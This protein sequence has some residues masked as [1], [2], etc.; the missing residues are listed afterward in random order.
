MKDED[1]VRGSDKGGG[2]EEG[3]ARRGGRPLGRI[4]CMA[5]SGP[6]GRAEQKCLYSRELNYRGAAQCHNIISSCAVNKHRIL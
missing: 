6:R 3:K 2:D 1:E 5:V 4:V